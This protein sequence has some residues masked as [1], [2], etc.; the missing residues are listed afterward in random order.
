MCNYNVCMNECV[1]FNGRVKPG[2]LINLEA[3]MV[4]HDVTV[5]LPNTLSGHVVHDCK[6]L[7]S[8]QLCSALLSRSFRSV[9]SRKLK[10]K[11][12]QLLKDHK[13]GNISVPSST[14]GSYFSTDTN[15]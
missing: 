12:V 8:K 11:K 4:T 3:V 5:S 15:I 13:K 7:E 9:F 14:R 1:V 2:G 10:K 6:H